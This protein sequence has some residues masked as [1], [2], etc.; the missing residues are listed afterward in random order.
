MKEDKKCPKCEST[1]IL[2]IESVAANEET[3]SLQRQPTFL[4]AVTGRGSKGRT[5]ELEAYICNECL[6]VEMYLKK[7]LSADGSYITWA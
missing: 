3:G 1:E 4:L 6:Y 7:S 2:K 5:G